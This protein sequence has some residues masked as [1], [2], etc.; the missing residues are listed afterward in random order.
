MRQARPGLPAFV[1]ERVQVAKACRARLLGT[2][3]PGRRH[4]TEVVRGEIGERASVSRRMDD[5]LLA[6]ETS[7]NRRVEIRHDPDL[8]AGRVRRPAGRA[9]DVRLGRRPILAALAERAFGLVVAGGLGTEHAGPPATPRRDQ[10]V[11]AAE[12]VDAK[13]GTWLGR[14]Q[15]P[16]SPAGWLS[17]VGPEAARSMNGLMMSIGIGRIIVD[18]RSD[19]ISSIVCR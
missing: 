17:A 2:R 16:A 7:G 10:H 14:G 4:A 5:D 19:E 6:T 1:D 9:D 11:G 13:L 8:P 18:E 15:R 12:R 3:A